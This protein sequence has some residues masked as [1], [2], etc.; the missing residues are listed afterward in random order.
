MTSSSILDKLIGRQERM[1]TSFILL[2]KEEEE[3]VTSILAVVIA[4]YL[5]C[6][7]NSTSSR[8]VASVRVKV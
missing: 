5:V 1:M 3:R 8:V 7:I 6:T 2:E 4:E